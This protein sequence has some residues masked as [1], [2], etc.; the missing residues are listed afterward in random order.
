MES[1]LKSQLD[2]V[3]DRLSAE[4]HVTDAGRQSLQRWFLDTLET[5]RRGWKGRLKD[6]AR[7]ADVEH[8]QTLAA[9]AAI[10]QLI[11]HMINR[12]PVSSVAEV[13]DSMSRA[14]PSSATAGAEI[15][16]S[17]STDRKVDRLAQLDRYWTAIDRYINHLESERAAC[18]RVL[19][20][21]DDDAVDL[22]SELQSRLGDM[23][24]EAARKT[25][26]AT[27]TTENGELR[28]RLRSVVRSERVAKERHEREVNDLKKTIMTLEQ[29]LLKQTELI[30]KLST[31]PI[32]APR[33]D[34]SVQTDLVRRVLAA[35]RWQP[36]AATTNPLAASFAASLVS[37]P[38]HDDQTSDGVT[39]G[40]LLSEP[41]MGNGLFPS[42]HGSQQQQ[43]Q[44]QQHESGASTATTSSSVR[45]GEEFYRKLSVTIT[46]HN[47]NNSSNAT[48]TS[49]S[50]PPLAASSI[51]SHDAA[52]A[53]G[54]GG[55]SGSVAAVGARPSVQMQTMAV[56][57]PN[58]VT[59]SAEDATGAASGRLPVDWRAYSPTYLRGQVSK[60]FNVVFVMIV[61]DVAFVVV[62]TTRVNEAYF[63][64]RVQLFASTC[65]LVK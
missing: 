39:I 60:F 64:Y 50:L 47:G 63:D 6:A 62:A 44:T 12:L 61:G 28:D 24:K 16:D 9:H 17:D 48:S 21:A 31:S 42:I 38:H 22:A 57:L 51:G 8:R 13:S 41:P 32:V 30:E 52:A 11:G 43:Q 2:A 54:A 36:P 49:P 33:H 25:L 5:E 1:D 59:T 23:E 7:A 27:L 55:G 34:K 4:R 40:A 37:T 3:L 65:E 10:Q 20:I 18:L 46:H 15:N 19:K 35:S 29:H 14:S 53:T 56:V 58:I 45:N 26:M